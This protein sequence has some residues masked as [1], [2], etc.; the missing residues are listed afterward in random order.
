MKN[1]G[2]TLVEL[3]G[4]I[5]I[6]GIIG[7][8]VTPLVINLINGGK[9]DVNNMQIE[10]IKRAAKN[11]TNANIYSMDCTENPCDITIG[12][13]KSSGYLEAKDLKN[14][15]TEDPISDDDIV[16]VIRE[17]GKYKYIYPVE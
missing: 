3:L 14:A 13:L 8:L 12:N 15:A 7:V 4:V 17:N 1:K 9:E 10:A 16:R 5:V 11:Y 2:F 6:L